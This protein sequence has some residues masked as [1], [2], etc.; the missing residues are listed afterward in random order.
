MRIFGFLDQK[1]SK[2][3]LILSQI[4]DCYGVIK[5]PTNGP[6]IAP[7]RVNHRHP[8]PVC[9]LTPLQSYFGGHFQSINYSERN[10]LNFHFS[11]YKSYFFEVKKT[12]TNWK[13]DAYI[14]IF[15]K[16]AKF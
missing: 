6:P 15:Q 10:F 1:R 5:R 3:N 14:N 11:Q 16:N 7:M 9:P 13:T 4:F 2:K 12:T 8:K